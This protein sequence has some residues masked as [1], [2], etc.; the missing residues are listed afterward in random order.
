M[1][2]KK[3][4]NIILLILFFLSYFLSDAQL[5]DLKS[6]S[7]YNI[8]AGSGAINN[9][10]G[11]IIT[12]DFGYN[13]GS[14]TGFPPGVIN[15]DTNFSNATSASV[16]ADIDTAYSYLLSLTCDTTIGTTLG[17]SQTLTAGVY[18]LG[19][20]SNIVDTLILD[21]QNDPNAVFIFKI[22]GA[23]STSTNSYIS[24]INSASVCNVFW[25]V[26]GAFASGG[27]SVFKGS[28]IGNGQIILGL[29]TDL[30]G[31][32]LTKTGAIDIDSSTSFLPSSCV[33]LLPI[34]LLSFNGMYISNNIIELN[35]A[36]ASETNNHF[37]SIEKSIDLENFI[38]IAQIKGSL[39]SNSTLEYQ[40]L[41]FLA[42]QKT[43]YYRLKQT[44]YDGNVKLLKTIEVHNYL[45]FKN[46]Y[47]SVFPNPHN[48]FL[49]IVDE[50]TSNTNHS[51]LSIIN[52][53]GKIVLE[54]NLS[55]KHTIVETNL[56]AGIYYYIIK[57][58]DNS[59]ER[60]NILVY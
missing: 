16:F 40:F 50:E 48:R 17:N 13:T 45:N 43:L 22:G 20:A 19:G 49:H 54:V 10:G 33:I 28:I 1:N 51:E 29:G 18:C 7:S 12:G 15:G 30:E 42:N 2:F 14:V 47:V 57:K 36:S 35:W 60:G 58:G 37:Y 52:S 4:Q 21:G 53:I 34:E 6:A 9:I 8:F 38:E 11:T 59:I 55:Q 32:A 39:Y 56:K 46:N 24:L 23:L 5:P 44:D 26:D 3:I 27:N 25:N 41:D 31:R